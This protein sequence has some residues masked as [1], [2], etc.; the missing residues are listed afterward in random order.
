VSDWKPKPTAGIKL[1]GL[2]LSMEAGFVFSRLDGHT[3]VAD[4]GSLTG[5]TPEAVQQALRQLLELGALQSEGAPADLLPVP[6]DTG[7]GAAE[8]PPAEAVEGEEGDAAGLEAGEGDEEAD[9]DDDQALEAEV[10]RGDYRAIYAQRFRDLNG[11]A[12]AGEAQRAQGDVLS[13]LCL[14]ALPEVI[15]AVLDN[16][17][18]GP[19]QARLIAR[20]HHTVQG[21]G[22]LL[23]RTEFA[24]D[25]QVRHLLLRNP[26][27]SEPLLAKLYAGRRLKDLFAAARSHEI[28]DA[29]RRAVRNLLRQRFASA[30]PDDKL[31]LIWTSEGRVLAVL[32]G[33]ALDGKT[34]QLLCERPIGSITLIQNFAR[35]PPTPQ[36]LLRYLLSQP[37]VTRSVPLRNM[38][39][40]HPNAPKER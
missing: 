3:R 40:R 13:A 10:E 17:N 32:I 29:V 1:A 35:W 30:A 25:A 39:K 7:P 28:T 2:P 22:Q 9:Q 38:L 14:D 19:T 33:V 20:H 24:R 8:E 36:T 23:G 16:P 5:F 27:L 21:L 37:L 26:Q 12:R 11:A 34:V 18:A 31:E 4:L 6:P 15:R